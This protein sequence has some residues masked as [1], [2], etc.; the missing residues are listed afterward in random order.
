MHEILAMQQIGYVHF[1]NS[2]HLDLMVIFA[3]LDII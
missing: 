3:N 2:P 1:L